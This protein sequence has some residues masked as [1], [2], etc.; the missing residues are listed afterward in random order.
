MAKLTSAWAIYFN[1]NNGE[2]GG[3]CWW[4]KDLTAQIYKT[5]AEA[6][7]ALFRHFNKKK[8]SPILI[9]AVNQNYTIVK[10]EFEMYIQG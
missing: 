8:L 4:G 6:N 2:P 3:I 10:C 7:N 9:K 5:K 1:G